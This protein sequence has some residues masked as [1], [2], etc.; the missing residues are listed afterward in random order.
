MGLAVGLFL[1]LTYVPLTRAMDLGP[2]YTRDPEGAWSVRHQDLRNWRGLRWNF[3]KGFGEQSM[4]HW[5]APLGD[6]F[7][8][9]YPARRIWVVCQ[10]PGEAAQALGEIIVEQL[11]ARNEM[12]E[13][14]FFPYVQL[15]ITEFRP[16]DLWITLDQ[17]EDE[18]LILPGFFSVRGTVAMTIAPHLHAGL[19][20]TKEEVDAPFSTSLMHYD[21][22]R[23]GLLSAAGRWKHVGEQLALMVHLETQLQELRGAGTEPPAVLGIDLLHGPIRCERI[24]A[25]A[26][27][28][29]DVKQLKEGPAWM[30]HDLSAWSLKP[31]PDR[32][33]RIQDLAMALT[34]EGWT[35]RKGTPTGL[36]LEL[37][38][39]V[40]MVGAQV[41]RR[42]HDSAD[43]Q[44][45]ATFA[46]SPIGIQHFH[47]F[48]TGE[49]LEYLDQRMEQGLTQSQLH[50][51]LAQLSPERRQSLINSY[52]DQPA[53][54]APQKLGPP[55]HYQIIE[56]LLDPKLKQQ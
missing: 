27:L 47:P 13:V 29:K 33:R 54:D 16:P 31:G 5:R 40:L 22:S 44:S 45:D 50:A 42:F 3:G 53:Q 17:L 6:R 30:A 38:D 9:P 25:L 2:M 46:N 20:R 15:P 48:S 34:A 51:L 19:N 12:A 26:D 32:R 52:F 7:P 4:V 37:G 1:L 28:G 41:D 35:L 39:R 23:F 49:C 55:H 56:P 43:W 10:T 18:S 14:A 21:G 24:Q 11:L 8:T 36:I